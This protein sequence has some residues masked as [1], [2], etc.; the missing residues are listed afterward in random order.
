MPK[1]IICRVVPLFITVI[2]L[3]YDGRW[4]GSGAEKQFLEFSAEETTEK[5]KTTITFRI[6]PGCEWYEDAVK[7]CNYLMIDAG[8]E[9]GRGSVA[10]SS[11]VFSRL[12]APPTVILPGLLRMDK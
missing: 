11:R 1:M 9:P 10:D 3:K 5:D 4:R 2:H 7:L 12:A 6:L 8:K